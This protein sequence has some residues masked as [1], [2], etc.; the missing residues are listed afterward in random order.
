MQNPPIC[1]ILNRILNRRFSY[2]LSTE[3]LDEYRKVLLRK[4]I[5]MYHALT[6]DKVDTLFQQIV[7]NAI[8]RDFIERYLK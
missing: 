8:M 4:K 5:K 3:L 1:Q 6:D 7:I 2:L